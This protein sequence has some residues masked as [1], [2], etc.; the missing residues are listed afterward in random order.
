MVGFCVDSRQLRAGQVFV[1]LKTDK[2]DGHEFL[3]AALESGASAAIVAVMNP[4]VKLPQLIVKDTLAAFQAIAREHRRQF[5]GRVVGISGSAG[6]TSTKDLLAVLLGGVEA[7]AAN[8]GGGGL[9]TEGDLNKAG[10]DS[11]APASSRVL[12]TEGNLNNHIGVPLTLT[13]LDS[14]RH[15]FAVVEAGISA[16]GDMR[17]LADMIEPD[18]SL[19]TL[20]APA[21]TAE[22]GGLE[23]V[24]REKAV[25]PAATRAAGIA[26][27]SSE[28][29]EFAAFRNL[30]VHVM[31]VEQTDALPTVE[32]P[33]GRVCFTLAQHADHTA[34]SLVWG[35]PPPVVFTFRRVSDGMAQN[36]VLAICTALW[37]G[38]TPDAVQQRLANWKPA[39]LR[40]EIRRENGRLLYLDCYNANPASMADA[41]ETFAQIAPTNE[42]RL[43]VLG[44][45][46]ELGPESPSYHR[47][48]GRSLSLRAGDQV[49]AIGTHAEDICA[50]ASGSPDARSRIHIAQSAEAIAR[51]VDLWRGAVFIKGSRRYQLERALPAAA[52]DAAGRTV[53]PH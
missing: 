42:P 15:D 20:I 41:L 47:E 17:P 5:R 26:V 18:V 8:E 25:L 11:G 48:L 4:A 27:F 38:I 2:R 9:A 3:N 30:G 22:L 10:S 13:R 1:A 37:L 7:A 51:T 35:K 23:G 46:E 40:A 36:A 34:V 53:G 44:C 31:I 16:P 14:A 12:A 24:A 19:I 32:P 28:T 43:Y 49:F 6:K 50:G 33:K 21:H 39:K 45:M 29:A 52:A